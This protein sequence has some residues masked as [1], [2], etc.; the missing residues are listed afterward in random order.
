MNVHLIAIG[1]SIMH[2]LALALQAQGHQVSGSDDL[3]HE[4]SLGRLQEA[5]LLPPAYGWF[6]ERITTELDVVLVGM[7]AHADNPE[8]RRAKALGLSILSFPEFML[9]QARHKQRIVVAGSHGK[10]TITS[11]LM[12]ALK[13]VGYSFDYMVGG[14]VP[15]FER[16]VSFTADAP[17]MLLEGDEYPTSPLDPRPKFLH[18]E[19]HVLLLT[20][21]AWDHINAFPSEGVYL[22]QFRK[23]LL[24]L[25]KAA[26]CVYNK[27]DKRVRELVK[28]TLDESI[29]YLVPY[30]TPKHRFRDGV[31]E[32]KFE[33][34]YAPVSVYG[35]HMAANLMACHELLKT[36]ALPEERISEALAGFAGAGL[37]MEHVHEDQRT[38]VI[39]DYAHAPSKVAATVRA[40]QQRYPTKNLVIGLELNT[41]SSLNEAY[42]PHYKNVLHNAKHVV[43]FINRETLKSKRL[44]RISEK[45]L[46]QA[47]NEPSLRLAEDREA[48]VHLLRERRTGADVYLLMSSGSFDHLEVAELVADQPVGA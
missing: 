39:R 7:H 32:V 43:L 34:K 6:P 47:F 36:F 45:F 30:Q 46:R 16:T 27:S 33:K 10:T 29:H 20:G 9:A 44:K 40:V 24:S 37:R 15:G 19:P 1:G 42:L 14:T 5:G 28:T 38:I 21:I 23:L 13:H 11:M 17:I 8:L 26:M 2:N 35:E 31:M 41:Y 12:H 4:P 25:P 18:Y 48:L 3:I 22:E